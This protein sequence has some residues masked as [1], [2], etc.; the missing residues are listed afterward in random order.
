MDGKLQHA[1]QI[2]EQLEARR[3]RWETTETV[4]EWFAGKESTVSGVRDELLCNAHEFG[5]GRRAWGRR[6]GHVVRGHKAPPNH[7]RKAVPRHGL[8]SL[9]P[10]QMRSPLFVVL[11]RFGDAQDR[12]QPITA[13]DCT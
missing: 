7:N 1:L 10:V 3:E 8:P 11:L 4:R 2:A 9:P 5:V 13:A 6:E 12:L